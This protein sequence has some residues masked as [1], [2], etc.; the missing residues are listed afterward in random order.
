MY[1]TNGLSLVVGDRGT[2]MSISN[3]NFSFLQNPPALLEDNIGLTKSLVNSAQYIF[4]QGDPYWSM[5]IS[6]L[7][8]KHI[9]NLWEYAHFSANPLDKW[10]SDD[11]MWYYHNGD[12]NVAPDG[13]IYT[14]GTNDIT[15]PLSVEKAASYHV[16]AQIYDGLPNSNGVKFTIG[17]DLTY[18]FKPSR[19]AE[20]SYKWVD[21]GGISLNSQSELLISG[22]GGPA[23]ISKIAVVSET[24]VSEATQNI[25]TLLRSSAAKIT[26]LLDDRAWRYDADALIFNSEADYGRLVALSNSSVETSFYVFNED[27]YRLTLTFQSPA[28]DATVK[29]HIDNSVKSIK[30]TK[31][32]GGFS[33]E[34][35]IGSLELSRGSHSITV[36]AGVGDARFNMARLTNYA[37]G[38]ET[39]FQDSVGSGVVSYSM[40]SG[41]EYLVDATA[42]YLAFLEAGNGYW[43]LD[44]ES[45]TAA[46]ICIFNYGSL[47]PVDNPGGQYTLRYVGLGY[48][49]QGFLIGIVGT[50][51][52]GLGLK[53][54][55]RKRIVKEKP[56]L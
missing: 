14:E 38:I 43:K 5:L 27:S 55:H 26:Y 41:S 32:D 6:F 30:L 22:L 31:G 33:T 10:V 1:Q 50:V 49:E 23:A 9:V 21:L 54:L 36:E 12:L 15:I 24:E 18:I 28:K 45:G 39:Q 47:F 19:S 20:G 42:G 7:G 11:L 37:D 16:L 34:V 2:L 56:E 17:N 40:R 3:M 13:Y 44:G 25:S 51:L 46:P 8:E 53:F 48:I 29:V 4:F 52:M 35:E